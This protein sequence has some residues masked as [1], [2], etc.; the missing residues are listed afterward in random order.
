MVGTSGDRYS[1]SGIAS[2]SAFS[3]TMRRI[4][5][6]VAG[7]DRSGAQICSASSVARSQSPASVAASA[8]SLRGSGG[9][10]N[11]HTPE[12][13]G[14]RAAV[15]WGWETAKWTATAPPIEHPITA[16]RSTPWS[17]RMAATSSTTSNGALGGSDRPN[18][19]TSNRITR[20]VG[21]NA[22][23]WAS[24]IR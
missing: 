1:S 13:T 15:V 16:A 20:C 7:S 12:A 5:S 19:R 2:T 8:A 18:P 3:L 23:T 6:S 22:S 11:P 10:R 9:R 4:S 24:H 21:A 14:T 17:A